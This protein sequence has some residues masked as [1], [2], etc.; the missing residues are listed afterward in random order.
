[1]SGSIMQEEKK[2]KKAKSQKEKQIPSWET[3]TKQN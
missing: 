3:K 1:M 2:K